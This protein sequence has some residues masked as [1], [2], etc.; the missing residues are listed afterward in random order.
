M[1]IAHEEISKFNNTYVTSTHYPQI[2]CWPITLEE[3]SRVPKLTI[4]HRIDQ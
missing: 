2:N 4:N 1:Y 3:I